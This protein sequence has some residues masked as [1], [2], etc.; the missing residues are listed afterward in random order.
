MSKWV[1]RSNNW[2]AKNLKELDLSLNEPS[3]RVPKHITQLT[4]LKLSWSRLKGCIPFEIYNV[5]SLDILDVSHNLIPAELPPIRDNELAC[6]YLG[7][8]MHADPPCYAFLDEPFNGIEDLYCGTGVLACTN[9]PTSK[10]VSYNA[11]IIVS[12]IASFLALIFFTSFLVVK[13]RFGNRNWQPDNGA[14]KNG[15]IFSI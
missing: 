4:H 6:N 7:K 9:S 3:G 5:D 8:I 15:D 12:V 11:K 1:R 10:G 13:R 14:T 2:K